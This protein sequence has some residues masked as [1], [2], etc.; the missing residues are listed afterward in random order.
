MMQTT[1]QKNAHD[2]TDELPEQHQVLP[3]HDQSSLRSIGMSD[4]IKVIRFKKERKKRGAD[5]RALDAGR[6][7]NMGNRRWKSDVRSLKNT[8]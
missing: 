2:C 3:I 4:M 1:K 5:R 6:E 7:T 8:P